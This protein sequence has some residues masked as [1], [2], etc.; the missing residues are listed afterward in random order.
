LWSYIKSK[1]LDHTGV[2]TLKH[3]GSI[4][5]NSQDKAQLLADYF[6]SVFTQE[7]RSNIPALND[8]DA[9]PNIPQILVH[10][11][12]VAQLLSYIKMNKASG[13]DNLPAQFLQET[14]FEISPILTTIFQASLDQGVLPTVWKTAAVVPIFK[15]GNRSDS[16]N[17]RPI[18]L[19]CICF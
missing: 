3:Q 19:T 10:I 9:L 13:P 6:K 2:S 7:D 4:Y 14:T 16:A 11:D 5:T 18:S 12:G 17:Y 15:K 8:I 1:K